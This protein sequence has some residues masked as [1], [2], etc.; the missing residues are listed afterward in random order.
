MKVGLADDR[1]IDLDK[2]L[3]IVQSIEGIEIIFASQMR[4][5]LT[6]K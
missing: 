6:N 1:Q 4:M 2:L 5:K 3:A